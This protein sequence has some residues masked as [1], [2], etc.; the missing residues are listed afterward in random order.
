MVKGKET[1]R[2]LDGVETPPEGRT[3]W[4]YSRDE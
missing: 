4:R 1:L 2:A 3:K